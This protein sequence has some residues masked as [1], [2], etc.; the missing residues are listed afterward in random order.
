MQ[1][2]SRDDRLSGPER[3][4]EGAARDLP[5]VEIRRD[6]D[7]ARQEQIDD[8]P[9]RHVFIDEGDVVLE[10]EPFDGLHQVIAVGLPFVPAQLGVRLTRDHV[11]GGGVARHD[12]R[13]RFDHELDALARVDQ[14]KGRDDGSAR[15]AKLLLHPDAAVGMNRGHAVRY[16]HRRL[17]DVVLGVEDAC[18]R[19]GHH[20]SCDAEP[21]RRANRLPHRGRR[22]GRHSVQGGDD[23]L[24][25]SFK[26]GTQVI[27]ID[28]VLPCPVEAEFVLHVDDVGVGT[29]DRFS[30]RAVVPGVPLLDAPAHLAAIRPDLIGLVDRGHAAPD[31]WIGGAHRGHQVGR[32]GGDAAVS[33]QMRGD[34]DDPEVGHVVIPLEHHG[35]VRAASGTTSATKIARGQKKTGPAV[36]PG[37]KL[38][39]RP[40]PA[41]E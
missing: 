14:A 9:L 4:G 8:V 20:D 37:P 30:R 39:L 6:I 10:A 33:R 12:R 21:D 40:S 41:S 15:H 28:V 35:I 34:E 27:V 2:L 19:V 22:I 32:E 13:H 31:V 24:A 38:M 17:G 25:Q 16:H 7:V 18:R 36:G 26:E 11:E 3:V 1:V 23:R 29:V 5:R